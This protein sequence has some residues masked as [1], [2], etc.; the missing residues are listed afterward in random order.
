MAAEQHSKPARPAIPLMITKQLPFTHQRLLESVT[1][2]PD[3]W[4]QWLIAN[5]D[6]LNFIENHSDEWEVYGRKLEQENRDL[7]KKI[8]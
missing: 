8:Q 2:Q 5:Y 7:Q 1:Q 6:Y 3:Q 4:E